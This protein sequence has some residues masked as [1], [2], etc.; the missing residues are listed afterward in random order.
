MDEGLEHCLVVQALVEVVTPYLYAVLDFDRFL[1]NGRVQVVQYF[2]RLHYNTLNRVD[3]KQ[4][5]SV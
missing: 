2:F 1:V 4:K 3:L 5:T